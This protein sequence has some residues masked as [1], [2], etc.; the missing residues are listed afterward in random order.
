VPPFGASDDHLWYYTHLLRPTRLHEDRVLV[1]YALWHATHKKLQVIYVLWVG[2]ARTVYFHRVWLYIWW[3]PCQKHCMYTVYIWFWPTLDVGNDAQRLHPWRHRHQPRFDVVET[4]VQDAFTGNIE[5]KQVALPPLSTC[6][7]PTSVASLLCYIGETWI[8]TW[9]D[10]I[11]HNAQTVS[12][13]ICSTW[14]AGPKK[15][16]IKQLR[17]RGNLLPPSQTDCK[18]LLI[19]PTMQVALLEI[20]SSRTLEPP[21]LLSS[22]NLYGVCVCVCVCMCMCMCVCVCVCAR[23]CVYVCVCVSVPVCVFAMQ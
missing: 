19:T 14:S 20:G 15:G 16:T 4:F 9:T 11:M 21:W 5:I 2:L 10:C 23:V 6:I 1:L 12:C 8:W 17:R 3:V 22:H 18:L 7:Q 13:T